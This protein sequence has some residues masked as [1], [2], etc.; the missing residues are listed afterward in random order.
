MVKPKKKC[1]FCDNLAVDHGGEHLW[2]NWINRELPK[3]M[4]F[5]ASRRLSLHSQPIEFVQAGLKEKVPSVC[6][7]CNH[8][9]MSNLTAKIKDD[10]RDTII[11]AA[12]F[13]LDARG[14]ALLA[15][16][17]FMKAVV[18]DYCYNLDEPFFTRAACARF[19]KSLNIPFFV[20]VWFA[21]YQGNS[22]YAFHGSISLAEATFGP[23]EG[24]EFFCYTYVLGPLV[25]Q[26]LAP[27]W[28]DIRRRSLP[29]V[30]LTPNKRWQRAAIQFWPYIRQA[31]SWPPQLYLGDDMIKQFFNRF[32]APINVPLR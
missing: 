30:T 18:Q 27:R 19:R 6:D 21:A 20:K 26:L 2:D 8:G 22:P 11:D 16:Y 3:K 9:W 17:I 23:L 12:P 10:F 29:L 32:Q 13:S 14:A 4:K 28:K 7:E 15:S 1:A 5:N 25:L 24:M 31:L